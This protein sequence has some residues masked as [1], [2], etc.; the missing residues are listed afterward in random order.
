[1]LKSLIFSCKQDESNTNYNMF[2][3]NK[4]LSPIGKDHSITRYFFLKRCPFFTRKQFLMHRTR[5]NCL[6]NNSGFIQS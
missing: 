4:A 5:S 1:M 2:V 6:N 3:I